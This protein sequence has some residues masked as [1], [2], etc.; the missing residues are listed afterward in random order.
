MHFIGSGGLGTASEQMKTTRML[1]AAAVLLAGCVTMNPMAFDKTTRQVDVSAK[2]VVLMTFEV[3]RAEQS[4]YVPKPSTVNVRRLDAGPSTELLHFRMIE[5]AD[6][7]THAGGHDVFALRMAL[8]P[9]RYELDSIGGLAT[10]FPF[11]G[12]FVVPLMMD[13]ALPAHAVTYVGHVKATLRSRGDR[14]FRA[15]PL[16]PLID[17]AA[18]GLSTGTFDVVLDDATD[19]DVALFRGGFPALGDV[20]VGTALLTPFDR[21]RVERIIDNGKW[22]TPEPAAGPAH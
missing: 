21:P 10:A 4:R 3:S 19:A 20:P 7:L 2:S 22:D 14:E 16:I 17:Q 11:V 15:G 5:K 1:P 18:T 13:F 6:R 12:T 9:G 8:D